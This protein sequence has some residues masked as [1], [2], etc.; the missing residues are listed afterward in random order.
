MLE[1]KQQLVNCGNQAL[2]CRC[3]VGVQC[4]LTSALYID[5]VKKYTSHNGGHEER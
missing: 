1:M 3:N 2:L 4:Q 5:P